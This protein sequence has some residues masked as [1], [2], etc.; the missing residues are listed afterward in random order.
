MALVLRSFYSSY[1]WL[2]HDYQDPRVDKY[3]LT[4]SPMLIFGLTALYVYF[5]TNWGQRFMSKRPPYDLTNVIKVY[6]FT[7]IIFNLAIGSY[8][9]YYA[10]WRQTISISCGANDTTNDS[11]EMQQIILATY[12]YYMSKIID[13]LD[14]V[15]FVLRKKN[16]QITFLHVYHHG[17]M[18][19]ATFIYFKFLSGSHGTLLGVIN[20]YVH[21]I[22][23]SYYLLTSYRPELKNSLWWKKH[24]TQIQLIQFG[25]LVIHFLNPI[26]FFECQWPKAISLI[27]VIQNLFMFILFL[28]FYIKAYVRKSKKAQ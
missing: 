25:V 26:F 28:D 24:I 2:F 22:M 8:A 9:A 27:G 11:Y 19:I 17:G 18:V 16:N 15:F 23:Y 6:N 14:T 21:V 20:S 3:P 12:L 10:Y 1:H 13:L 5:V 4:S 7:Q